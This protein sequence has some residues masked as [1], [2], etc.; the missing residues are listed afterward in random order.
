MALPVLQRAWRRSAYETAPFFCSVNPC[1]EYICRAMI[2][3]MISIEPPAI[4]TIR[5]SA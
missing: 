1:C 5:A 3:F 2:V 4:F